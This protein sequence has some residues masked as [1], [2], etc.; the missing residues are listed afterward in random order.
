MDRLALDAYLTAWWLEVIAEAAIDIGVV[1]DAV[2]AVFATQ[3]DLSD[4]WAEPLGDSFLLRRAVRSF[5]VSF[6]VG[7]EGD[8]YRLEQLYKHVS[9]LSAA[10]YARVRW[11]VEPLQPED[12]QIGQVITVRSDFL[13]GPNVTGA[14]A[15]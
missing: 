12:E 7:V 14:E 15:W 2:E 4:A 11:I 1:L 13:T 9:E 10:A 3:P 5:A 6:D 8:T